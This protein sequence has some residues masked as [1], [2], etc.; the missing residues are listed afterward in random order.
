LEHE[1]FLLNDLAFGRE[2]NQ[3]RVLLTHE[4]ALSFL[5]DKGGVAVGRRE[6][7]RVFLDESGA[8]HEGSFSEAPSDFVPRDCRESVEAWD[9]SIQE[10]DQLLVLFRRVNFCEHF[11]AAL[12][13]QRDDEGVRFCGQDPGRAPLNPC[14]WVGYSKAL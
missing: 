9:A 5:D 6:V 1:V 4:H 2:G 11:F 13:A 3:G 14:Q 8:C 12:G 10:R 7:V